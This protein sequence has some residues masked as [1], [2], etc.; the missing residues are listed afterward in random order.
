MKVIKRDGSTVPF[1]R[2]KIEIAILKAMKNGSG[3]Y[4]PEIASN[5]SKRMNEKLKREDILDEGYKERW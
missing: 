3:I 1:D 4:I 5:I 2:T